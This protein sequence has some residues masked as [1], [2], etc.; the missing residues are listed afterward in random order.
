MTGKD[1]I[2]FIKNNHLENYQVEGAYSNLPN[3]VLSR[4][5]NFVNLVCLD[6][7]KTLLIIP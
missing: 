3:D 4:K 6:E 2:R 5:L 1:L 7:Y